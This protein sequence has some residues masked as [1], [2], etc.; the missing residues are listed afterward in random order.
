MNNEITRREFIVKG[1]TILTAL[2]LLQLLGEPI[3]RSG[4]KL[5][6]IILI[7]TDDLG[8]ADVGVFGAKGFKTPNLDEL[9]K[10]G[11]Q[12]KDYY[13]AAPTCTPSRAALLTG[14][15]PVRVGLPFVIGPKG[16]AWTKGKDNIGLNPEETTI[17]SMLKQVD[18]ATG[19]IGKWHLGDMK[20]FLPTHYGFDYYF[21][22]PYSHDMIKSNNPKWPDLPLIENEKVVELNPDLSQLTKRYTEKTLSFIVKNK[23]HPFFLYLAHSMPHVPLF[24]S[25]KFEGKSERG[26]YGDVVEEIDWSV[27]EIVKELK[28]LN[29]YEDTII[30]YTSDNGPWLIYGNHA[31]SAG[32]LREGKFTTF[33]GGQREPC[34][35]S[36]PQKIPKGVVSDKTFSAIDFLPTIAAITDTKLPDKKI[37]GKSV[38]SLWENKPGAQNP[39]EALYYYAEYDL[40]A[41]RWKNWKLHFHHNYDSVKV[42]GKDGKQGISVAKTIDLSLF[43][44]KNDPGEKIN[45][46]DKHTDIVKKMRD[47]AKKFDAELKKNARPCGIVKEKQD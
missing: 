28:E 25:E 20:E 11:I 9:A 8:Y 30:I 24:A 34:I 29:L 10:N 37:D 35:I 4:D 14:C 15:Y 7:Y 39:H 12:F 38:L 45:L 46:A 6:N 16:P 32:N 3:F 18:Y 19:C 17:A 22:L 42:P 43:D 40:Q 47:M 41:V 26:L 23:T 21:G 1:T 5:P 13:S 36:W 31:G 33:E 44:L 27:G 2:P